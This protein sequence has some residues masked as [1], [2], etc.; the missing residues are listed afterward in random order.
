MALNLAKGQETLPYISNAME[1]EYPV[2]TSMSIFITNLKRIYLIVL[3][4][5]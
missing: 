1:V 5:M 3:T 2:D 4:I